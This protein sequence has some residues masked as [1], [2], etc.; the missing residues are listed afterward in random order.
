MEFGLILPL[1]M[2]MLLG[3]F[4]M[5]RAVLYYSTISNAAREAVRVGIVDQDFAGIRLEAVDSAAAV[6][7]VDPARV[8][9]S[10]LAPDLTASGTCPTK[11]AVGC[12]VKVR[13]EYDFIPATPFVGVLNLSAET[14]QPIER[15]N[16][17][18]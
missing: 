17:S 12:I 9:P 3:L 18:P 11:R 6:M 14:H 5:G 15:T 10:I 7:A 16:P 2:L 13:V 4:D 8:E 1:F